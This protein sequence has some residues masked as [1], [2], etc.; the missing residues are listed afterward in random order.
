MVNV[1]TT[2]SDAVCVPF[3]AAPPG[4]VD[5]AAFVVGAAPPVVELTFVLPLLPEVG[6]F[7]VVPPVPLAAPV[8]LSSAPQPTTWVTKVDSAVSAR[9][10][11]TLNRLPQETSCLR[12]FS[13]HLGSDMEQT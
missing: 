11:E 7:C 3:P 9:K 6:D 2:E 13:S 8:E 12:I 5:E 1:P 4:L 10:N